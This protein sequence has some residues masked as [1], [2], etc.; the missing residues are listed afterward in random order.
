L[1]KVAREVGRF[2]RLFGIEFRRLSHSSSADAIVYKT[3]LQN[4]K[5]FIRASSWPSANMTQVQYRHGP[6]AN[7]ARFM[8]ASASA[9][10]AD[11]F[12]PNFSILPIA[13]TTIYAA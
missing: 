5:I 3:H 2:W 1:I 4:T 8:R 10:F 9:D 12:T 13:T 6:S 7:A 11:L